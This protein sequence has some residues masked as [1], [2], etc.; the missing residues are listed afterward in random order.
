[1][2][3]TA[4]QKIVAA[5]RLEQGN[6]NGKPLPYREFADVL[7]AGIPHL[8]NL[9]F[10]AVANWETGANDPAIET[11]IYIF[12]MTDNGDWRRDFAADLMAAK[13]PSNWLPQGSIGKRILK[14]TTQE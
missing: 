14:E 3:Q 11:L 12:S 13:L 4:I 1:M 9:T 8:S 2:P 5:Y 6:G 10:Q 7:K